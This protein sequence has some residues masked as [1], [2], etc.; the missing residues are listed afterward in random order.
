[1]CHPRSLHSTRYNSVAFD[2]VRNV[3]VSASTAHLEE[4]DV[5]TILKDMHS[6]DP[7]CMKIQTLAK[8]N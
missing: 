4:S 1:M 7:H 5:N 3:V 8:V 2:Q 6:T